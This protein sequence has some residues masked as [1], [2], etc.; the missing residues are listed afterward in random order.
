MGFSNI[1]LAWIHGIVRHHAGMAT[2]NI[3]TSFWHGHME[4]SGIMLA[5]PHGIFRHHAG[6]NTW[7]FRQCW[8][9]YMEFSYIMLA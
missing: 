7:I 1:M 5:W 6:M 4:F 2:W 9:G 8:H 3:Q